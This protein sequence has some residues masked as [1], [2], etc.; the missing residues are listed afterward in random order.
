M[1]Q[2]CLDEVGILQPLVVTVGKTPGKYLLIAGERRLRAAKMAGLTHV[3][4]VLRRFANTGPDHQAACMLIENLLRR[5]LGKR[6]L[7]N[8]G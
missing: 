5:C 1:L 6:R 2:A 8:R 3:P 4:I 7:K